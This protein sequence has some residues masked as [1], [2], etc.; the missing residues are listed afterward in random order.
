LRNNARE[1]VVTNYS[2]ETMVRRTEGALS[3]LIA[4]RPA[5]EIAH[6]YA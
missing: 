6:E 5:Q 1:R 2:L 4:G 3:Q